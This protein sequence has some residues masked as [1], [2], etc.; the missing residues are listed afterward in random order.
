MGEGGLAPLARGRAPVAVEAV[1]DLE[2][3]MKEAISL[4]ASTRPHPNPRVG[5][6]VLDPAGRVLSR[7]AHSGPGK[8]H[9][10]VAALEA[11]GEQARGGTLVVTLEPCDHHGRTPPCT[12]AILAAGIARVLVGA[13]DPDPRVA[14]RGLARLRSAGKE[15]VS[16]IAA[17]EVEAQDPAYFYH[18]RTGRPRVTLK[19][20]LTL[21]G[22]AAAA[23]GTSQWITS[24]EARED[25]HRL[26]AEADA[27]VIGA[28]TL[29]ADDPL[30]SVR[31]EGYEGPQ[32]RAV[33]V[34]GRRPLPQTARLW[35]RR[36]LVLAPAPAGSGGEVVVVPGPGGVDLPAAMAALG[37]RGLLE[38]LVE[39]GP[40]LAGALLRERLVDRGV[41]YFGA[42]LG[43][44]E[45][46]PA[47]AGPFATLADARAVRMT[48]A[49]PVGPD[50]RVEFVVEEV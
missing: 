12:E 28:G 47:L 10:E 8:A 36:P 15:V 27:V 34:A 46:T 16:G 50:L 33:V 32:P 35:E 19:A 26:R 14:G 48:G 11:A 7:A 23:D 29:R 6:L 49:R 37:E 44:G 42:R 17:A 18:R 1:V 45:G 24:G 41:F 9:A 13:V 31:L 22:R 4:V 25:A 2:R 39:G 40:T 20:A 43:G 21:D 30:L 38:V 5:A 3:L